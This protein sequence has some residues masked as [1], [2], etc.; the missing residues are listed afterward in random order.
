MKWPCVSSED[1]KSVER[2]REKHLQEIVKKWFFMATYQIKVEMS[3]EIS[4]HSEK[5]FALKGRD[6]SGAFVT[7]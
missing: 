1:K 6:S 4:I 2:R 7:M 3:T 5:G